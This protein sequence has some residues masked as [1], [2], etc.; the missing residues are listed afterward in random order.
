VLS[1]KEQRSYAGLVA[2]FALAKKDYDEAKR[3]YERQLLMTQQAGNTPGDLASV[4]YN[5]GNVHLG[6]GDVATAIAQFTTALNHANTAALTSFVPLIL[7]NMGVAF[8]QGG[9]QKQALA[10]FS[11]ARVYA[12]KLNQPPTEAH[13]LDCMAK[14]HVTANNPHEAEQCWRQALAAYDRISAPALRQERDAGKHLIVLQL[15]Q[16]YRA[17]KNA[18]GLAALQREAS[19]GRT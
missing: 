8:F 13:I 12:Q 19:H 1:P 4:H 5:L 2:T 7:T 11:T 10:A 14:C 6:Q 17:T 15:E 18:A 9:E 3:L 16:H